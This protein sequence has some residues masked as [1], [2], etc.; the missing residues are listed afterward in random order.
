MALVYT[1]EFWERALELQ[2]MR[3]KVCEKCFVRHGQDISKLFD[4][5]LQKKRLAVVRVALRVGKKIH[6]DNLG[7]FCTD[8]RRGH[9]VRAPKIKPSDLEQLFPELELREPE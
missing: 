7:F 1:A 5:P 8:C 3:V 9:V 6:P 2:D 4:P